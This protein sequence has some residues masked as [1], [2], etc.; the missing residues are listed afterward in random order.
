M[1]RAILVPSL[2]AA[3]LGTLAAA[4]PAAAVPQAGTLRGTVGPG[5]TI[6]MSKRSV[7]PGRY[8]L[9]IRDR[10]DIHNFRLRG[11]GLNRAT[12]VGARGTVVWTVRLRKGT[13][14]FVCDPHASSMTGT[15]RVR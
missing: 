10:S 1:R 15:L 5:F 8:T 7:A 9:T 14:T 2:T 13:Y 11:P 6:S 4:G 12:G 3:L